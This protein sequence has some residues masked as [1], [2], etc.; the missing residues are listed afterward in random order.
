MDIVEEG[1]ITQDEPVSAIIE[2]LIGLKNYPN[3]VLRIT[4]QDS[5]LEGRIAVTQGLYVLGGRVN[6]TESV[7]Y[8]AIKALLSV[9]NGTY[10][11]LDPDKTSLADVNQTLWIMLEKIRSLLP[12]LPSTPESLFD[13]DRQRLSAGAHQL[14]GLG[15]GLAEKQPGRESKPL[16]TGKASKS[17]KFNASAW[18]TFCMTVAIIFGIMIGIGAII[19]FGSA[20]N[21][22]Q[23]AHPAP[24]A[25][26][27][28]PSP[29]PA[30]KG[31]RTH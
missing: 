4:D 13:L 28:E 18:G 5:D 16:I 1:K 8:P 9:R 6:N 2:T 11:I 29:A 23:S 20:W 3:L 7:G 27:V 12:N 26:V 31:R 17:R 25:K 15:I 30:Q 22:R 24:P 19:V 21:S 10:A 14:S